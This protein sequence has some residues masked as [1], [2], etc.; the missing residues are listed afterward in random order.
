MSTQLKICG[1]TNLEDALFCVDLGVDYLGFNFFPGSPRY[2]STQAAHLIIQ[3]LPSDTKSVGILVR[4]RLNDVMEII[5]QSGVEL[6]QIIEPQDITDYSK[7]PVPVIAVERISAQKLISE[8]FN[9]HGASMILL[10]TYTPNELGGS[11]K[12]FNWS[13]IPESIPRKYLVLAGGITPDNIEEAV[14]QVRPAVID[15][16]SGAESKPGIK[17]LGKVKLLL[18]RIRDK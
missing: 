16:A 13:L 4:P 8:K 14:K 17:D 9:L 18:E 6:V 1:I 3:Q 10:D 2:I 15:V 5:Q 7:V 11:G 12:A